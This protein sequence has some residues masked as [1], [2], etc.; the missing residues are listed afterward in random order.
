MKK[1]R[2]VAI[3]GLDCRFPGARDA[4][5]F[6]ANLQGGVESVSFF[7]DEELANTGV[8]PELLR[9][10]NYIK[11]RSLLDDIDL[12]DAEF[13]GYSPKEAAAMDPQQR[14]FLETAWQALEN[15]GYDGEK[16]EGA[17][18]V[19]A[20]CYLDTYLLANLCENREFIESLLSFKKIGAFQ[21]F[22][23]NDKDYLTTRA[24]YKLNL[25]GPAITVQTACSTSLV[26]VCQACQSL[27]QGQCDLALAGGVTITVPQKKGY[28]YQEGGMLSPDGHCRAF[29]ANAQG[30]VFGSGIGL[31]VLKRLEEA[32]A[33]RDSIYAV[34]KGSALNNDGSVK[35]SYTAP[36]IDGQTEVISLAQGLAGIPPESITY[37]EA[38]G[39]G[40]PLG[41]PIEIAA[42]TEAFRQGTD[43]K[44]FCAIGSVKTNIGHLDVAAGVAGLIKTTLALRHKLIPPSLH[45]TEPNPKID[46]ANSPFYV[47]TRLTEWKANGVPRRA[48]VS[49]FGVGGTNAHVVLEEAP[50]VEPSG[51][52]RPWQ[53]LMLSAKSAS[54]LENATSNLVAYLK[55]NPGVN[56]GDVAYTLQ[57]GRRDFKHR[58]IV[59]CREVGDAVASLEKLDP[60]WVF[61][62]AQERKDS[63]VVFMFPGQGAQRVNMGAELYQSEP[64]FRAEIDRCAELLRDE[65]QQDLRQVLYPAPDQVEA[66]EKQIIQTAITQPA[67]FVVEYAM[68][69]LWRS[70]GVKPAAMIGHSVGEYVAGC[71]AGVFTLE[72]ALRL[73]AQRA[74]LVQ[75]QPAGAMTAVRL[76]EKDLLPRLGVPLSIAAINSPNLCVVAGPFA[77]I[78]ELEQQLEKEGIAARRLKTSHAFHSAMMDPVLAP[79][80]EVLQRTPFEA[81]QIPYV[82]N[83]TGRWVSDA[84]ATDPHYWAGHVRQAVRFADGVGELF[85]EPQQLLLEVGPGQTLSTLARQ[86]PGRLPD[87]TVLSSFAESPELVSVLTTLGRLWLAGGSVDWKGFYAQERRHRIALPGYPFERRRHWVEAP[88]HARPQSREEIAA[89]Q[90]HSEPDQEPNGVTPMPESRITT[91]PTRPERIVAALRTTLHELSGIDL[92]L[93]D[94]A[95]T[96]VELGFDSLFLTQARQSLQGKFGVK[97]TFRHLMEESPSLATLAAYIDEQLAPDAFP[98]ETPAPQSPEAAVSSGAVPTPGTS[99]VKLAELSSAAA[100]SSPGATTIERIL[101]QQLQAMSQLFGEQLAFLRRDQNAQMPSPSNGQSTKTTPGFTVPP[102]EHPAAVHESNGRCHATPAPRA[103]AKPFGPY[104]PVSKAADGGL[105]PAQRKWLDQ[106]TARYTAR[107]AGSKKFAEAHRDGLADPRSVAGFRLLWKELV[108]QIV[109]DRAHGSRL[110]DIDGNEYLDLTMGFGVNLF[111]HSPAFVADAVAQQLQKGVQIG[112]QSP[113][114]GEVADLIREFTGT[115]RVTFCNTGSEAVMAALRIARTVTGRSKIAFFSGDYHGMFD[116]VL[117]RP[118]HGE[119]NFHSMPIAPGIP[120]KAGE[121]V[122]ILEYGS[123]KAL[124]VLRAHAHELAAVLVEPVQSRNPEL[125]PA[126][127]LLELRRLTELSGTVLI[128]D[129]VITGFRVHPG[130]A[131][132]L[133]GI[134]PDLA[135]YGKVIGGGFPIGAL[136]GK[137]ACMDALDGGSWTYGDESSPEADM[138]F[139][140]GTFVRHPLALAA[141]RA[142]LLHL[143]A[144]GPALQEALNA[145]TAGMFKRLNEVFDQR[146]VP[147][148]VMHFGS[149]F[150]FHFPPEWPYVSLFIYAALSKGLY[151]REAHQNCFLSTAHTASDVERAIDIVKECVEEMG[152]ADLLPRRRAPESGKEGAPL[153]HSQN[154]RAAVSAAS[155][156]EASAPL[157]EAQREIWLACQLG[158]EASC[159]YNESLTVRFRGPL[160]LEALRGAF[161]QV[162]ARHESLRTVISGAGDTQQFLPATAVEAELPFADWS[163]LV[164]SVQQARLDEVHSQEANTPFDLVNGPLF[165]G[166]IIKLSEQLH[167]L[168]FTGHHLICD[169]SSS[170]VILAELGQ[171]YSAS[172][173]GRLCSLNPAKQFGEFAREQAGRLASPEGAEDETWWVSQF[174]EPIPSLELPSDQ[175]RSLDSINRAGIAR[176]VIPSETFQALKRVSALLGCTVFATLLCGFNV[177]L[178]RVSR[179]DELAVG[180]FSSGQAMSGWSDLVGHCVNMLPIRSSLRGKSTFKEYVTAVKSLLLD[181]NEHGNYTYGRLLQKLRLAREPGRSPLL[182]AIFNLER[183]G[184]EGVTF[185]GLEIE[186]DQ[187]PHGFV[188]FSLFLN[189]R[190]TASELIL[191]LEYNQGLF[192]A[193]T[194]QRWL[195]HYQTLLQ[196]L[197]A[198]PQAMIAEL[199]LLQ[200]AEKDRLLRQWNETDAEYPGNACLHQ[201][202]ERQT[203]ETP[204]ATALVFGDQL[205]TYRELNERAETLAGHLQHLGVGPESLVGI[206]MERSPAM[207]AG[208][209]GVLK[210]GGAYVP[211]DPAYPR[212]RLAFILKDTAAPVLLTN[213]GEDRNWIE[214]LPE[215]EIMDLE[216]F[217][218]GDGSGTCRQHERLENGPAP[219][220]LA[221]V[222][223]TSGS[224]GIPKGVQIEHRNAV[225]FVHWAKTVFTREELSGVLA[226]TS[227]CFDLSVFEIFLPLAC[228]GTVV[229][230]RDA[231]ELATLPARNKVTLINTVPSAM[232]E[233]LRMEAVPESVQTV[234]LAGEPLSASLVQELYGMPRIEKVYDL[235]GP[236][237]S[238]TYSTFALRQKEGPVTIGRPIANTHIHILDSHLQPVPIGVPGELFVGGAGLARGYLNRPELTAEKFIVSPIGGG[239]KRL[240]R[241]G[242]L[243]RYLPDGNIEFLGR[244]DQQVKV[245]GFRIEPGE[246]ESAIKQH[247]SVR[248]SVVL[249]REDRPGDKR[250]V[251]YVV[252]ETPTDAN[253]GQT[254]GKWLSNIVSQFES[255]YSAAIEETSRESLTTRDP[256]LSIYAWSGLE[257]TEEEVTEWIDQVAARI[258]PLQPKRLLEIGCGTGLVLF[259]IAPEVA[260]YVATD[261]SQ[262]AIDNVE[263]RLQGDK[264]ASRV[265]L[266]CRMAD[267]FEELP[268]GFDGVILNAVLE[269]FP[270][271][272]YLLRVLKGAVDVVKPGGFVFLGAVPNLA[273]HDVFHAG[274]QLRLARDGA[275]AEEVWK[276]ARKRRAEDQRLLVTPEFFRG[277]SQEIPQITHVEIKA[278]GGSFENEASRLIEDTYYDVILHLGARPPENG[279]GCWTDWQQAPLDLDGLVR[280]LGKMDGKWIGLANVPHNRVLSRLHA[281]E[282]LKSWPGTV[283]ELREALKARPAET[284]LDELLSRTLHCKVEVAWSHSA[285]DGLCDVVLWRDRE[286]DASAPIAPVSD[287]DRDRKAFKSL[288]SHVG[289]PLHAKLARELVPDLRAFLAARLPAY[290]VP[291]ELVLLEEIPR[292]PNGKIDRRALP[293]PRQEEIVS[294]ES[295]VAPRTSAEQTLARIWCDVLGVKQVGINDDFFELGGHSLLV[296]QVV[297]RI[298]HTFQVE[299]PMRRLFEQ[300]TIAGIAP[301][302]EDLLVREVAELSEEDA[303]R[304]A[305]RAG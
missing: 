170:A 290:M 237:E 47:N 137:R 37:I 122:L 36:S 228:G 29:D 224:T 278:L 233:L 30:T 210:A 172:C 38:H 27:L 82:S 134:R 298:R 274:E 72:A 139:F 157:T 119:P 63:P 52:S 101:N 225:S 142:S 159:A 300:P 269:Y 152:D 34:I 94:A 258:L 267:N 118:N 64:V 32:L 115:E 230:A 35:V 93:A 262:V 28:L 243:A 304:L 92:S 127:F 282:L 83:V 136:A 191:D 98:A 226:S 213:G 51:V 109:V 4:A 77:A 208:M 171:C 8:D 166:R 88:V 254:E 149:L 165:R 236:S 244:I 125:Q 69:R 279:L 3:I 284:G 240:Y 40:T 140:A 147:I 50:V 46:F 131:Q 285:E 158:P 183:K 212:E 178:H 299:I 11:A 48:G 113:L 287:R 219:E 296:T 185:Q 305:A 295:F 79:F 264:L 239:S 193:E 110:W 199:P 192:K 146:G 18:G 235:Y 67:L 255:G 217:A 242:D 84:E 270:G 250:L 214:E 61:T 145:T 203:K 160:D 177:F 102:A 297:S 302:L 73:V 154:G 218:L 95:S 45:F 283:G 56:L 275:P 68:A 26:A 195:G 31:V 70:W 252:P 196:G 231:L 276:R 85:K 57:T 39:T 42:L 58:R 5:A 129:E 180:I 53:L 184:D 22:L 189:I 151:L 135:T 86:H 181:V 123:P 266:F 144:R 7:S 280:E 99:P 10:P 75:S 20:G 148:H 25:K 128:F 245:R 97:I 241:T 87:Q 194:M 198:N 201:L 223:Y 197:I 202:F 251:A 111:G 188:T 253:G 90:K 65:L 89:P 114:A 277:L 6:W 76:P 273:L 247:A 132:A 138:T 59:L 104:R 161:R 182:D 167:L 271:A 286:G 205:V 100:G 13:F 108:Y 71:L 17:I 187:N 112:P 133:F 292:T 81:P 259:R 209:L 281:V 175:P 121:D 153:L 174:L 169:G 215:L 74:R 272:D 260:E 216:T 162:V 103:E 291:G 150:R 249:A 257:K 14:V 141:A 248:D 173:Q 124:E 19:F 263:H 44:A 106:L 80:T 190:E 62:Q 9:N 96:F 246:I 221:Y 176:G 15:A 229:L 179:Q 222:I 126:G 130:G 268:R 60:K 54:A 156:P 168:I 206:C 303:Q 289:N 24:S 143:K 116:E 117:L 66:A 204:N 1:S 43:K 232:T 2:A 211:L 155:T 91:P 234:N 107:T 163:A 261:L 207:V 294:E 238:T 49:S 186:V 220:N 16:Y 265:K 55:R 256:T 105:T 301:L 78:Q 21:T 41:D 227:I 120:P 293:A 12:F 288:R 33:D 200:E 23:G 164:A